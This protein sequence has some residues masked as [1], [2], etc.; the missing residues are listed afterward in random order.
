M[1]IYIYIFMCIY[2]YKYWKN[3]FIYI[4]QLHWILTDYVY[5]K[6]AGC[7]EASGIG[8]WIKDYCFSHGVFWRSWLTCC[9]YCGWFAWIIR[10]FGSYPCHV[11]VIVVLRILFNVLG[12]SVTIAGRFFI[13]KINRNSFAYSVFSFLNNSSTQ[14][15]ACC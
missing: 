4:S 2:I 12:T 6:W 5:V 11:Y 13:Y 10:E 3:I 15:L 7:C 14:V 1:Y 8:S 9:P